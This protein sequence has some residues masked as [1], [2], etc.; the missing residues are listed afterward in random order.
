M[1]FVKITVAAADIVVAVLGASVVASVSGVIIVVAGPAMTM[2]VI[3]AKVPGSGRSLRLQSAG[4]R[5]L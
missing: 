1:V 2:V 4:A 3:V 5:L